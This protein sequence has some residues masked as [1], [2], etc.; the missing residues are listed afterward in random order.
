MKEGKYDKLVRDKI[1]E[2]IEA[3]GY[4]AKFHSVKKDSEEYGKR[5]FDKLDEEITEFKEDPSIDE[6]ADIM[7]VMTAI[8]IHRGFDLLEIKSVKQNKRK[9]RG[10][11]SEGI[12]LES[13]KKNGEK[14]KTKV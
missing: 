4:N 10:A 12:I 2:I 6:F 3:D 13:V 5:L 9:H 1:P 8:A 14:K 7:E 11:F